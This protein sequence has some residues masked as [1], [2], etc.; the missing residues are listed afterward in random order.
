VR[1]VALVLIAGLSCVVTTADAR[2]QQHRE[3]GS[4]AGRPL[5]DALRVLQA[6]GLKIIF[7]SE[8]VRAGMRVKSEPLATDDR[9]ILDELLGQHGLEVQPG[10][11]GMLVVVRAGPRPATIVAARESGAMIRGVVVD[12]R[13]AAPLSGVLVRIGEADDGVVSD[14]TGRFELPGV[15]PGPTTLV[16]SL[17][18]YSLARPEITVPPAGVLDLTVVLADGTGTYTEDLGHGRPVSRRRHRRA[19]R[20]D[21]QQRRPVRSPRGAERRPASGGQ[22]LPAVM[23]GNDYRSEFSVRGSDFRHVGLTID[24]MGTAGLYAVRDDP[25]GGSVALINGDVV[26]TMTLLT[27]ASPQDRPARAAGG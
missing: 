3:Q 7:S 6:R 16:V 8:L 23:T 25:S 24:G 18:G 19:S 4:F 21:A 11:R 1:I 9:G 5:A 14:T 26:D 13:S 22:A 2:P 27:G 15:A 10:P 20:D 12:A 17:V